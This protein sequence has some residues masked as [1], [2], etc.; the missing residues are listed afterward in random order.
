ML[1]NTSFEITDPILEDIEQL[2]DEAAFVGDTFEGKVTSSK[3]VVGQTSADTVMQKM[4]LRDSPSEEV[5]RKGFR[6][7]K[8]QDRVYLAPVKTS[9]ARGDIQNTNMVY[10][11]VELSDDGTFIPYIRNNQYF[12]FN[13]DTLLSELQT[14]E[15]RLQSIDV[16]SKEEASGAKATA[17][18]EEVNDG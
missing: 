11:A 15:Q 7:A 3:F 4:T 8:T 18:L 17:V 14:N 5:A 12:V 1:N 2:S 16:M 13:I 9:F 10:Q 6:T